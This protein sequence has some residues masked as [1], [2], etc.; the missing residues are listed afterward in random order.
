MP[1]TDN[2]I[3]YWELEE[4]NGTRVDAVTATGNDLTDTNTV[5]SNTGKVGTA[6]QFARVNQ[7]CLQRASN[8]SL[9]MGDIDFSI[10]CWVYLDSKPS[11]GYPIIVSKS[12]TPGPP[13]DDE[14]LLYYYQ[15]ADRFIAGISNDG[16][17]RVEATANN[18]GIPN[19]STWYFL[20]YLYNAT[21]NILSI[22]VNNGTK[23]TASQSGGAYAS[24]ASFMIGTYSDN[25][26][27]AANFDGRIDQ[28]GI[29]KRLLTDDDL[30]FLYNGGL[31]RSYASLTGPPPPAPGTSTP[32]I[33]AANFG[34]F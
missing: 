23:D 14:Y 18:F 10:V 9:Q 2:L 31:G 17:T 27:S 11:G 8:T 6:A 26:D 34:F 29:W 16:T 21:T 28:V 1:I 30:T 4:T 20:A 13:A 3:S 25:S 22:S 32:N 19:L 7:E 33:G 5:L 12:S 15:T 24:T